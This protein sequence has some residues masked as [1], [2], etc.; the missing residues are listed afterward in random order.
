MGF[1]WG[2]E[3]VGVPQEPLGFAML[4]NMWDLAGCL[5]TGSLHHHPQLLPR[6]VYGFVTTSVLDRQALTLSKHFLGFLLSILMLQGG[7]FIHNVF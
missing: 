2:K 1:F 3:S 4:L 6:I 7:H 5:E